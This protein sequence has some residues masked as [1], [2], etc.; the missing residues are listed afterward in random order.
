[1]KKIFGPILLCFSSITIAA[2]FNC[3]KAKTKIEKIICSNDPLNQLDENLLISYKVALGLT[4]DKGTLKKN[5]LAWLSK[6]RN[7]CKDNICLERVYREQIGNLNSISSSEMAKNSEP[8]I[9]PDELYRLLNIRSFNSSYGP[10]LQYYCESY[11]KDYF[12]I[13]NAKLSKDGIELS[14]GDDL[15]SISIISKNRIV[16]SNKISSGSYNTIDEYIVHYD[17]KFED[18]RSQETF[19]EVPGDC[20]HFIPNTMP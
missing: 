19:I 16:I 13:E 15:W 2:S 6:M 14:Y 12:P 4:E 10:R 5:Q 11:L 7:K 18:W 8:G 1:M 20:T 9:N 17:K 3:E